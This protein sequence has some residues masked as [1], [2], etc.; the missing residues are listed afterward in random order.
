MKSEHS[1]LSTKKVALLVII[2]GIVV[3][4]G[5]LGIFLIKFSGNQ[6]ENPGI[7][8]N[9]NMWQIST[10]AH[11]SPTD[12]PSPSIAVDSRCGIH[13]C[14]NDGSIKYAYKPLNG[15]YWNISIIE[16]PNSGI[17]KY[18]SLTLDANDGVHVCYTIHKSDMKIDDVLK[19]AHKSRENNSWKIIQIAPTEDTKGKITF[20]DV[21]IFVDSKKDIYICYREALVN[22]S[23]FIYDSLKYCF[24]QSNQEGWK[25]ST[26]EYTNNSSKSIAASSSIGVDSQGNIYIVYSYWNYWMVYKDKIYLKCAYK[27]EGNSWKITIVDNSA[28]AGEYCSLAIDSNNG[29]HISYMDYVNLSSPNPKS[30]LKYAYKSKD[31][32]WEISVVDPTPKVGGWTSIAVDQKGG[33]HISYYDYKNGS[34]KYA[35]KPKNGSWITMTV[36]NSAPVV[37]EYSSIAVDKEG[38]VHIVYYAHSQ[39]AIKYAYKPPSNSFTKNTQKNFTDSNISFSYSYIAGEWK[40]RFK[41]MDI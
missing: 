35:Y 8:E 21:S 17:P 20:G 12:Y 33:V 25:I 36:D 41:V 27:L 13:I 29:I 16:N 40:I 2:V 9:E 1:K 39:R 18:C 19:Y 4:G 34:L 11:I 5:M 32:D 24:K 7:T 23:T 37:G 15:K 10:V 30:V 31:G 3:A 26:I 6:N 28:T 38:G 14:F 22:S